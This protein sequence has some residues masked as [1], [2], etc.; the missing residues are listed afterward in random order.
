MCLLQS[1]CSRNVFQFNGNLS[2]TWRVFFFCLIKVLVGLGF[3]AVGGRSEIEASGSELTT[4][5]VWYIL[6]IIFATYAMLPLPLLWSV[7]AAGATVIIHLT[8]FIVVH[9]LRGSNNPSPWEVFCY[10][11]HTHTH[12]HTLSLFLDFYIF[13]YVLCVSIMANFPLDG[14]SKD[15]YCI[16]VSSGADFVLY[17][18]MNFAG[19]YAKYLTDRAGRKAFLE[20]RRSHEMRCKAEKENDKQEKLLLSGSDTDWQCQY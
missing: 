4:H 17:A 13:Q 5:M 8:S 10:I 19:L 16:A 18:A 1:S 2:A 20:T 7:A 15:W 6:F 3:D 11:N 12:I 14:P 9:S